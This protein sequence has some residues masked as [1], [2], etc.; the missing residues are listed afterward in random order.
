MKKLGYIGVVVILFFITRSTYSDYMVHRSVEYC[1]ESCSIAQYPEGHWLQIRRE[2]FTYEECYA[3]CI[4]GLEAGMTTI[5]PE[6]RT[7]STSSK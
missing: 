4:E 1:K 3:Q 7:I 5:P 6:L 2:R